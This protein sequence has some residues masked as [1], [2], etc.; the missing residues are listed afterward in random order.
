MFR[1]NEISELLN[2]NDSFSRDNYL[3][4]NDIMNFAI[5]VKSSNES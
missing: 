1:V 4:Y 3:N 2:L 5:K